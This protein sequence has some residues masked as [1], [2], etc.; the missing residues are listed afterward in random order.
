MKE[1]KHE[2]IWDEHIYNQ[3]LWCKHCG[4]LKSTIE[5]M[6]DEHKPECL[7]NT[8]G[9]GTV[10]CTCD[11]PNESKPMQE[12]EMPITWEQID[13]AIEVALTASAPQLAIHHLIDR[14]IEKLGEEIK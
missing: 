6:Q 14:V 4:L 2:Y 3:R 8:R 11:F 13:K 10:Y 7:I 9:T 12:P 1:C 5:S